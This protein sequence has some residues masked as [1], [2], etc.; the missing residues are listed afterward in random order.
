MPAHG[1]DRNLYNI[2]VEEGF[3]P[4][5]KESH[6]GIELEIGIGIQETRIRYTDI[7]TLALP[8]TGRLL[9]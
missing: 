3:F 7:L 5:A 1:T 9:P 4:K 8:L 2:Y 6:Q